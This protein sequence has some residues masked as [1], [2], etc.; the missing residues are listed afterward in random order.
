MVQACLGKKKRP[1]LQNND[2]KQAQSSDSKPS[3]P[4][5]QKK[6]RERGG[7]KY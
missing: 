7:T 3:I 4:K 6:V 5:K 2:G 1:Y